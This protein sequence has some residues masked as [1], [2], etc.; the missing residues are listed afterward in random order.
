MK[1]FTQVVA[2][3]HM[4]NHRCSVAP[5]ATTTLY[6]NVAHRYKAILQ[7]TPHILIT[8]HEKSLGRRKRLFKF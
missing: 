8:P 5:H 2:V 1:I 6:R 4:N 7:R 3:R